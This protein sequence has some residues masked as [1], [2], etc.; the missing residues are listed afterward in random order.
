MIKSAYTCIRSLFQSSNSIDQ[1]KPEEVD[2][3]TALAFFKKQQGQYEK[4][5]DYLRGKVDSNKAIIDVGANIGFFTL[6][7]LE[8]I[9]FNGEAYLFEPIPN[10]ANACI[11]TFEGKPWKVHIHPFAL[12][13]ENGKASLFLAGD[14]NIGWN[15]L[16]VEK[17]SK[18]MRSVDVE[19]KRFDSLGISDM[20]LI[21]IDVEGAEYRV[22]AGMMETLKT[23]NPLPI[24]VVEVVWG[25]SSHP[26]WDRELAVFNDL[27]GL[28]YQAVDLNEEKIDIENITSTQDVIFL[29]SS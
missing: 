21:K 15:T 9:D 1:P 16:E 18:D 26:H 23:L 5:T 2:Y 12:G 28:G 4:V 10:L 29:P 25:K 11:Q 8:K 19:V 3:G 24:I 7:L 17:T 14:G 22:L 20:G 27:F 13:E 6:T